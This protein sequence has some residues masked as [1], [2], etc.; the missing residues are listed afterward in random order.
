MLVFLEPNEVP[1]VTIIKN[2][3]IYICIYIYT[4]INIYIYMYHTAQGHSVWNPKG[5]K[6]TPLKINDTNYTSI[7]S[8]TNIHSI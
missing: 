5:I 7:E 6:C 3:Y 8:S 1:Y 2:I 4:N